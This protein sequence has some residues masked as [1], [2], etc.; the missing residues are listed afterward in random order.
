M[1]DYCRDKRKSAELF[2]D[3]GLKSPEIYP[4]S[5]IKFPCF[6]KPYDGSCSVGAA[7]LLDASMLTDVLLKNDKMMF[8]ELID[9]DRYTEFTVDIYYDRNG[10]LK[11]LVPRQRIEVRGGEVSKGVTRKGV[12]YDYLLERMKSLQGARGCITFQVFVDIDSQEFYALEINPRF[13]GGF[14]LTNES[15]A[16]YPE[17]LIR[18]YLIGEEV[19]FH[20]GWKENLMM[21]RYDAQVLV[22]NAD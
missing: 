19:T 5:D 4:V 17:W 16:K 12:V 10:L 20:D 22:E 8:M 6:S 11:C 18:E 14:P 7:T 21:L 3:L 15:G 13:G 1:V 2:K 9:I